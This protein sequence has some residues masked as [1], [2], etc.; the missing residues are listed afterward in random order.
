MRGDRK[1][2]EKEELVETQEKQEQNRK[3][4][5]KD[6]SIEVKAEIKEVLSNYVYVDDAEV[7]NKKLVQNFNETIEKID[8]KIDTLINKVEETDIKNIRNMIIQFADD[9][10]SGAK[11][12]TVAY[13]HVLH[14]YDYYKNVLKANSY[15]DEEVQFIKAE[16]KRTNG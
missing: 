6:V 15:I 16:W 7:S 2:R 8:N 9:L 13:K 11:R 12:S 4:L 5:V 10:R 1:Q 3:Q 14:S